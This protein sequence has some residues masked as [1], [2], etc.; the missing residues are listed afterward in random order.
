DAVDTASIWKTKHALGIEHDEAKLDWDE[1]L[2]G[3]NE[4]RRKLASR[5][6]GH[7]LESAAGTGRQVGMY[8]GQKV[9][10]LTLVDQS[11][12]MLD[13]AR[14]KWTKR[15]I[16][17]ATRFLLGDLGRDEV[18][19]HLKPPGEDKFD[20]VVQTM[21][22]CSTPEPVTML[23]NLGK[24]VAPDGQILLLEHGRGKWRWLNRLLDHTAL[25]HAKEHG[26]WWNRDIEDIVKK[27]GLE[28][29]EFETH[30]FGTL[31]WIVLK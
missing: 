25:D 6:R 20:T 29:E 10:S 12:A 28:I 13:F 1:S 2:A 5:A 21:G 24:V 3:I 8:D 16:Q 31:F 30:N 14:D 17:I 4:L 18:G 7:V 11:S 27:S 22:L 26:C 23:K 19:E 15:K 9:Q